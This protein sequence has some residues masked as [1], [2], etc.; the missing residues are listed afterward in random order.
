MF[1]YFGRKGRLAP[2]YP[3]PAYPL[4]I[5]PFAGSAAYTLH[6]RPSEALLIE[7][8]ERVVDLW[9]SLLSLGREGI[10]E[11]PLPVVGE[12]TSDLFHLLAMASKSSLSVEKYRVSEW[13]RESF[14]LNRKLAARCVEDARRYQY[15]SGD[16]REAPD[17]EA[18]WF[19]DPPYQNIRDGYLWGSREIDYA[20][21]SEWCRSRRGQVIVC[22]Q[23]GADW[24]PFSPFAVQQNVQASGRSKEVVWMDISL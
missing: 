12:Q 20:D 16:Y 24:L 3:P 19:I 14:L 22:E 15:V 4:V 13:A 18:T 6:H 10:S 21:L 2:K 7:K 1:Y 17:V 8:D 5:E 11:Y 23:E 9:H